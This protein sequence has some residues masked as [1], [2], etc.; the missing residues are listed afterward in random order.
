AGY[1]AAG[2]P[3]LAGFGEKGAAAVLAAFEHLEEIPSDPRAWPD[4]VRGRDTLARTLAEHRKEALLYRTLATLRTDAPIDTSLATLEHQGVPRQPFE[5]F[6]RQGDSP[7]LLSRV[8]RW[9][10]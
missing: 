6:A 1:R 9:A 5:L 7:G 8:T 3:G 10:A 4:S 2:I